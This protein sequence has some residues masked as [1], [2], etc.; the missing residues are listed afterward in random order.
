MSLSILIKLAVHWRLIRSVRHRSVPSL[1]LLSAGH[2]T[3][4][5]C[6]ASISI[7]KESA[8]E[9]FVEIGRD[10]THIP[11]QRSLDNYTD[12]HLTCIAGKAIVYQTRDL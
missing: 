5:P 7:R 10:I 9:G 8:R 1:D 3:F 2:V 4:S 11:S 12:T 6:P